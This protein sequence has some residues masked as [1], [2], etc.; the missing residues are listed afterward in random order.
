[1]EEIDKN[2]VKKWISVGN[3]GA[4]APK[5][6]TTHC[7]YCGVLAIFS[8]D[9]LQDDYVRFVVISHAAC[10]GCSEIV[11]VFSMRKLK[12]PKNKDHNPDNVYM[13]PPSSKYYRMPVFGDEV[14]DPLRRAFLATV[15]AYNSQSYANTAA[16]GRRTL[17]GIFKYLNETDKREGNLARM[18]DLAANNEDFAGPLRK[19]SHAVREGGNLG[20]HFDLESEPDEEVA[21]QIVELTEYL[22][23]YLYVLPTRIKRLESALDK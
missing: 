11:K 10:P 9:G 15:D 5:S 4:L 13:Y 16:S 14:P 1:M 23:S 17:E 22:I 2:K 7:P 20:A 21:R 8:L 12:N 18:I 6:L 19:L 3:F